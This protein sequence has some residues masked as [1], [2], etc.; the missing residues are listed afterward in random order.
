MSNNKTTILIAD[1]HEL[2]RKGIISL[3]IEEPNLQTIAEANNG[4]DLIYK[5]LKFKPDLIISDISMPELSG[6]EAITTLTENNRGLKVLFL[7]MYTGEDYIYH[8]IKAGGS[9]LINKD[10]PREKLIYAIERV[11]KG[12]KYFGDDLKEDKIS[13]F[14]RDYEKNLIVE[15]KIINPDFT[16]QEIGV[17]LLIAEGHSSSIIADKLFISKRTVDTHRVNIIR[18]L[19]LHSASQLIKYAVEFSEKRKKKTT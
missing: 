2:V 4:K 10:S 15:K 8:C 14:I 5:Y 18:K 1:D 11:T 3:L 13:Q 19:G 16:D 17:L 6:L 7:S 12:K 9:G